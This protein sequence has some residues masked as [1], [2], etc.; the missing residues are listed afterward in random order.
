[1]LQRAETSKAYNDVAGTLAPMLGF[2]HVSFNSSSRVCV[3]PL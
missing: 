3:Q 2:G 1:M